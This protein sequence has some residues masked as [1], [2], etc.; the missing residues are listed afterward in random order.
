MAITTNQ[1]LTLPNGTD[2]AN[3]PLA[4]T[5]YNT[6]VENRLVQRYL[7]SADRTA[8]NALP[9]EGELSYLADV[10][11]YD[12]YT[13]TAWLP[14]I[15]SYASG[16]DGTLY[17]SASVAYTTAGAAVV[18]AAIVVPPSGIV[19]VSWTGLIGNSAAANTTLIATQLNTGAVVG[20]GVTVVAA[21]DGDSISIVGTNQVRTSA[22]VFYTGLTAGNTVNAFL[23]HRV[24][25]G[26][27][28]FARRVLKIEQA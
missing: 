14:L 19:Q 17:T 2:N 24:S 18:G 12:K 27:G 5:N 9:F 6:G 4:M 11:R 23:M 3:V 7:S 28:T 26:T 15:P 8:R 21:S 16:Q 13:G 1:G 22:M 20:A 10:D 25:A